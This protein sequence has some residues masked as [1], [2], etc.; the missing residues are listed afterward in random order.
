MKK[1]KKFQKAPSRPNLTRH[2][3]V[4]VTEEEYTTILGRATKSSQKNLSAY[5]RHKLLKSDKFIILSDEERSFLQE[6]VAA[7][8]DIKR[9]I[10]AVE[11]ATKD[12]SEDYRKRYILSL[13]VQRLW[14]PAINRVFN[15]IAN[16]T[17]K[18]NIEK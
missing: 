17:E 2:F 16:F 5:C 7:R 11:A 6:L 8:T 4:R 13:G 18:Y 1:R 12:K 10:V 9:F 14:S 3:D 15:F